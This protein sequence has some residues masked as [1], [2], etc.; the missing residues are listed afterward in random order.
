MILKEYESRNTRLQ[1]M[2]VSDEDLIKQM[3]M[4]EKILEIKGWESGLYLNFL[5]KWKYQPL[6]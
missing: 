5:Q 6:P 1:E 3:P 2:M 4:A